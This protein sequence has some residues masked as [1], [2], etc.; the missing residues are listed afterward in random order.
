MNLSAEIFATHGKVLSSAAPP[1]WSAHTFQTCSRRHDARFSIQEKHQTT[2]LR[3]IE[4][5]KYTHA[6]VASI[7]SPKKDPKNAN[8]FAFK[9][10]GTF[11][12]LESID[13]RFGRAIDKI[14]RRSK[15]ARN[16]DDLMAQ[17]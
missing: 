16:F 4:P 13:V 17:L 11:S 2:N 10:N 3:K 14:Q 8:S 9:S 15:L 12:G 1:K 6:I 5:S 7:A